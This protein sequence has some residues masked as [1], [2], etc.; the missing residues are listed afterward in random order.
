MLEKVISGGQTGAD[1]GGLEA[2]RT[3]VVDTGGFAPKGFMTEDGPDP[4][5]RERYGLVEHPS[6]DYC[7]RT[8][9]NV[10]ESC[11]TALFGNTFSAGSLLTR[12]LC[13]KHKKPIIE[14][15]TP[16]TLKDFM[17]K[18]DI[19]ILNVAGNRESK[20]PGIYDATRQIVESAI[21]MLWR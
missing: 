11:G 19:T 21:T 3:V 16:E 8:E 20:N 13:R 5:L 18:H 12:S 6:S 9:A 14:N 1:R 15:P 17:L 10:L 2:A 4:T 7:A